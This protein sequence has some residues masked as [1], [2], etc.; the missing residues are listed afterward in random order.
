M[1]NTLKNPKRF[2]PL[3]ENTPTN[4]AMKMAWD[5]KYVYWAAYME[6]YRLYDNLRTEVLRR[7]SLLSDSGDNHV[8]N[9]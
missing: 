9:P 4:H 3:A 8:S 6:L 5:G 2:H 1:S 7:E